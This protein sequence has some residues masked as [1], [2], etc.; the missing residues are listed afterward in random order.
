MKSI[1]GYEDKY[2]IS[3]KGKVFSLISNRFLKGTVNRYGYLV[4][5]LCKGKR[6]EQK[7]FFIHRLVAQAFLEKDLTRP[8]V[9]HKDGNKQ[10]AH[11]SNLEW[12]TPSENELHSY[13]VLKK[14]PNTPMLNRKGILCPSSKKVISL[15]KDTLEV[16]KIYDSITDVEKDGFTQ[17]AVSS[18]VLGK[19]NYHGNLRWIYFD[20]LGKTIK[21]TEELKLQEKI[22]R[23]SSVSAYK[24]GIKI[25]SFICLQDAADFINVKS[26]GNISSCC[27]GRK[28]T[29]GGYEWRYN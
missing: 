22:N 18:V 16:I 17:S 25:K 21:S 13:K 5:V 20:D 7:Q 27:R 4:V 11:V 9:N 19:K 1:E 15:N 3:K 26:V 23:S 14:K 8:H 6:K 28:N 12:C 29:V 2:L 24:N 10:N